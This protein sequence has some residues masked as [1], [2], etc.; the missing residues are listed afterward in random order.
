MG[1]DSFGRLSNS[2]PEI[3]LALGGAVKLQDVR[4]YDVKQ[5]IGVS[6]SDYA[7]AQAWIPR[8]FKD[9]TRVIRPG[10]GSKPRLLTHHAVFDLAIAQALIDGGVRAGDA[11]R[12]SHLFCAANIN[13]QGYAQL[14]DKIRAIAN[15]RDGHATF[16]V[17]DRGESSVHHV[18]MNGALSQLPFEKALLAMTILNMHPLLIAVGMKLDPVPSYPPPEEDS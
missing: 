3:D 17:M 1:L 2:G 4:Y 8:F 10:Q 15:N 14:R 18:D 13:H 5:S 9:D 16:M 12:A 6:G 7:N 11:F